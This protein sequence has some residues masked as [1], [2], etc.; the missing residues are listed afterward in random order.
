MRGKEWSQPQIPGFNW[1][2]NNPTKSTDSTSNTVSVSKE[3]SPPSP[4]KKKPKF[5]T[6]RPGTT[7]FSGPGGDKTTHS[8][9]HVQEGFT[10]RIVIKA[11]REGTISFWVEDPNGRRILVT[12]LPGRNKGF[13]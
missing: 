13:I 3:V 10:G 11:V 6:I 1:E 12:K 4:E 5:L 8:V 9:S 2:G 7:E